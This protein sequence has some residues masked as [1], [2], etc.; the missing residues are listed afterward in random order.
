MTDPASIDAVFDKV[1]EMWGGLDFVVHAIA[2]A[3]KDQLTG[4]Y[5]DTPSDNFNTT[6]PHPS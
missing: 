2:V 4:R 3:D 5:V 6:L 1:R